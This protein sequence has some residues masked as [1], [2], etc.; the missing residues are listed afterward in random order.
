MARAAHDQ[1]ATDSFASIFAADGVTDSAGATGSD[2]D[3]AK[4]VTFAVPSTSS[5]DLVV[6]V[7]PLHGS[8]DRARIRAGSEKTFVG[9]TADGAKGTIERIDVKNAVGGSTAT[10]DWMIAA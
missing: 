3:K 2:G 5:G 9:T 1:N 4:A 6:I 7:Y 8:A 10:Y